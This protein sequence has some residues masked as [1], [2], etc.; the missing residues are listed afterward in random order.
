ML[1]RLRTTAALV[2]GS[3]ALADAQTSTHLSRPAFDHVPT[4]EGYFSS[5]DGTRL[6]YRIAG[7]SGKTV[8]FLHGGPGLGI[9]DGGY[10]LEPLAARG[11]RMAM[12]NERGGGRSQVVTDT[13]RLGI[14]SYV[15]DVEAFAAH[16]HL[17][18]FSIIAISW[19]AAIAARFAAAHPGRIERIVW[20]SPMPPT[21]QY[22]KQRDVFE[23][24]L[25]S[26]AE[27][28]RAAKMEADWAR[29]EDAQAQRWCREYFG[30]S[31]RFYVADIRNLTRTRGDYCDY[32]PDA[33]RNMLRVGEISEGSMGNYDFIPVLRSI[34]VPSLTIEG[35]KTRI[36][37]DATRAW[38]GALPDSRM[39]LVPDAGHM[40]WIDQ[41]ELVIAAIDE[42]LRGH[43]PSNARQLAADR[44]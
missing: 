23:S 7:Q 2:V 37:L 25:L 30:M 40:N 28:E 33:I 14:D 42:F 32:P 22:S 20:L 27:R 1:L 9:D 11:Y 36:P 16:L 35:E 10:D 41:P 21:L 31:D 24:S 34:A 17:Q 15:R 26:A 6:F 3:L 5:F 29:M 38:A 43:W 12:L 19:G 39:M 44:R 13:A 8:V 4:R 18:K